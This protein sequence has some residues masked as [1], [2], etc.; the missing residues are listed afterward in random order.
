[1][2]PI[3][4]LVRVILEWRDNAHD[5]IHGLLDQDTEGEKERKKTIDEYLQAHNC[6]DYYSR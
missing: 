3:F 5:L 6:H 1:M 2:A 4:R